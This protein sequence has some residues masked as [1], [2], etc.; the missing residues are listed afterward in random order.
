M[1]TQNTSNSNSPAH[2]SCKA[3]GESE[4]LVENLS[5]M[6]RYYWNQFLAELARAMSAEP[7]EDDRGMVTAD[8]TAI[9]DWMDDLEARVGLFIASARAA[10][11]DFLIAR[12]GPE[13]PD[14]ARHHADLLAL[15]RCAQM[16]A[17]V[18]TRF[19]WKAVP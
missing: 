4:A 15:C 18:L 7:N 19:P 2:E 9:L 13:D 6:A 14:M 11:L 10:A 17:E 12:D 8:A 5:P 3:G 16:R 1:T